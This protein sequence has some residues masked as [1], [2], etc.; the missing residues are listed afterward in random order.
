[1]GGSILARSVDGDL[2][3]LTRVT[4]AAW[5]GELRYHRDAGQLTDFAVRFFPIAA[6]TIESGQA[7]GILSLIPLEL[8]GLGTHGVYVD[9][10]GGLDLTAEERGDTPEEIASKPD[11][12]I[13]SWRLALRLGVPRLNAQLISRQRLLPTLDE[14]AVAE[15][16]AGATLH[17]DLRRVFLDA[18]AYRAHLRLY[19]GPGDDADQELDT[20][21]VQGEAWIRA[22]R[23]LL[24]GTTVEV[25]RSFVFAEPAPPGGGAPRFGHLVL[26]QIGWRAASTQPVD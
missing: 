6:D 1:M 26:A 9:A 25:G 14:G 15:R 20:W 5:F 19:H 23:H 7:I 22:G 11:L 8:I 10:Q 21:G 17:V 4:A 12:G 13:G 3:W 16:R 2:Q 24:V 18:E